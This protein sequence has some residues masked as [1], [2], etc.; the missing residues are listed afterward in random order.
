MVNGDVQL[1]FDLTYEGIMCQVNMEDLVLTPQK[2][3]RCVGPSETL[4][5][6]GESKKF[7]SKMLEMEAV[8]CPRKK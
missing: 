3:S 2:T 7:C 1:K 4:L 8:H 6:N 5:V